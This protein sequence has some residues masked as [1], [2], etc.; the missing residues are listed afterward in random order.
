L[1]IARSFA[2]CLLVASLFS[3]ARAESPAAKQ[4][5]PPAPDK[6]VVAAWEKAGAQFHWLHVVR[7]GEVLGKEAGDIKR[8]DRP[9]PGDIPSFGFLGFDFARPV[10]FRGL[11]APGVP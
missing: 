6:A 2:T 10:T 5:L 11:P 8:N 1:V 9:A 4:A 3:Q 7:A